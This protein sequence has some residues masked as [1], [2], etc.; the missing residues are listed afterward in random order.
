LTGAGSK[1]VPLTVTL[2]PTAPIVGE[3]PVMVGAD[4]TNTVNGSVL[5][6]DPAGVVTEMVPLVA[7]TGTLVTSWV[8]VADVTVAAV[9]LNVTEFCD[10]TA[11]KPVP[12][13]TTVVPTEAACGEK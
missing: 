9:P 11:L 8:A 3:N 6:A 13:M 2:T 7:P 1:F 4:D 12:E 5:M 10:G